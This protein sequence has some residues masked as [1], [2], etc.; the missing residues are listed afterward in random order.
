MLAKK[1]V[2]NKT[3]G[4]YQTIKYHVIEIE[5]DISITWI[6]DLFNL[7]DEDGDTAYFDYGICFGWDEI[8]SINVNKFINLRKNQLIHILAVLKGLSLVCMG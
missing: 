2:D 7:Y 6:V 8:H 3:E 5:E 1:M 4:E